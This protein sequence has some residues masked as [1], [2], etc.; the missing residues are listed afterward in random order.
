[1]GFEWVYGS[2]LVVLITVAAAMVPLMTDPTLVFGVRVPE[3]CLR[4]PE[5]V[6]IRHLYWLGLSVFGF[7]GIVLYGL[8]SAWTRTATLSMLLYGPLLALVGQFL[9]YLLCHSSVKQVKRRQQWYEGQRQRLVVDTDWLPSRRPHLHFAW[10]IPSWGIVA[11]SALLAGVSYPHLPGILPVHFD[12]HGRPDAWAPKT[13]TTV[14]TPVWIS[15]GL[16]LLIGGMAMLIQRA[17]LR[18]DASNPDAPRRE[19]QL[20]RTLLSGLW[21]LTAC[22]NAVFF[23]MEWVITHGAGQSKWISNI[24]LVLPLA[25]V[26][27][28]LI[29]TYRAAVRARRSSGPA[30]DGVDR[31]AAPLVIYNDDQQWL[32]GVIYFNRNDPAVFVPKRFGVGWTLNMAHPTAWLLIAIIIGIPVGLAV[33]GV[34][35]VHA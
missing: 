7:A 34:I 2:S 13:V 20:N 3:N 22:I 11:V 23:G 28:F 21:L 4:Q 9:V 17:P 29:V 6:R 16:T 5:L 26:V 35:S 8:I 15:L 19:W 30:G 1:M 14:F 10:A 25:A 24:A 12:L 27:G 33:F 18:R 31:P 32:A